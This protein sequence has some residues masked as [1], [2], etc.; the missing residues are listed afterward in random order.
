[1]YEAREGKIGFEVLGKYSSLYRDVILAFYLCI[2]KKT[3]QSAI[4]IFAKKYPQM[5]EP[6]SKSSSTS[7]APTKLHDCE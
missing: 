6:P 7:S 5:C 2:G 3:S 4:Y 1:M